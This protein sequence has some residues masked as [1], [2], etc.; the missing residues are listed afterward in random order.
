ME[1]NETSA[2]C[3]KKVLVDNHLTAL[4]LMKKKHALSLLRADEDRNIFDALCVS[5][6]HGHGFL[7]LDA[8]K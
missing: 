1:E 6:V 3:L 5:T 2:L 4:K 7:C 8:C